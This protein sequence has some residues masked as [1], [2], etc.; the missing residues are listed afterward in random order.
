MIPVLTL[1]LSKYYIDGSLILGGEGGN[2]LNF[3]EHLK[4]TSYQWFS[5][6]GQGMINLAP[7]GTGANILLLALIENIFKGPFIANF[8]FLHIRWFRTFL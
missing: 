3:T 4:S 8:M 2:V 7:S 5:V 1:A 6:Y